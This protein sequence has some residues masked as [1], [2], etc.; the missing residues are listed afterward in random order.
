MK[1]IDNFFKSLNSHNINYVH[2]KSNTNIKLA[3]TGIDDL[4][5][6]VDPKDQNNLEEIFKELKFVRAYSEKDKWQ[7]G[8]THFIGLDSSSEKLVHVHLH[9]ELSL[10]YDYDKGFKL[11]NVEKYLEGKKLYNNVVF[12]P[13]YENEY[14]ILVIRLILKNALTPFLLMLPNKQLSFIKNSKQKGV[15]KEGG[16]REFLD[17]KDKIDSEKLEI[18]LDNNFSFISKETFKY[19]EDILNTNLSVIDFFRAG[20]RLKKELKNFRDYGELTSIRKAFFRLYSNR[21]YSLLRKL[22]LH[23][24]ILG[25]KPQYGGRIVTFIGG[26]GAGKSTSISNLNNLLKSQLSTKVIHLGRPPTGFSGYVFKILGKIVGVLGFK[27]LAQSFNYLRVAVGRKS[28]FLKACKLRDQGVIVLQ[29]RMPIEGITAMDCP[30][31]KSIKNGKYKKFIKFEEE[32]YSF[33]NNVDQ[34]FILKLN[35]HIAVKRRPEDN[36]EE[37]LIRSGQVWDKEW[38]NSYTKEIDTKKRNVSDVLKITSETLWESINKPFVRAEVI[39]LNGTGKSTLLEEVENEIPNIIRFINTKDYKVL[40]FYI[41]LKHFFPSFKVLF[42]TKKI[43]YVKIYFKFFI[44]LEI[45]RKWNKINRYPN[46]NFILDQGPI[47]QLAF[48]YKEK[49]ISKK[50]VEDYLS[51]I[52]KAI[53]VILYLEAPEKLLYSRIKN[54]KGSITRGQFMSYEEFIVFCKA[55]N[56]SYKI[57]K[58]NYISYHKINTDKNSINQVFTNFKRLVYEKQFT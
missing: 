58:E 32:C 41:L 9:Y 27:D 48:L 14:C 6:L 11:P 19:L 53:P 4:D 5:I 12:L 8:I 49:C 22:K 38:E 47:F 40:S 16:Y 36:E 2:W 20:K 37:L 25:K 17:L 29:D 1:K 35:P 7:D 26:D 51:V 43:K 46:R 31:V 24:K 30:R 56:E 42:I 18:C 23:N 28:I 50:K 13:T 21:F 34:I 52:E 45:I 3:L 55:Y 44:N 15:V 33:I 54:R 39:G 10:G 57:V